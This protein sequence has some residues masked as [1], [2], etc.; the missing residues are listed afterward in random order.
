MATLTELTQDVPVGPRVDPDTVARSVADSGRVLVVLDDDPTGTQS[1]ADLPVLT[2]WSV[3]DLTWALTQ[4]KPAVYVMTNSRSLDP[5]DAEQR[6]R[7]VATAALQASQ[8]TGVPIGFVS[9]GDSTLRGHLPLEPNT[10]AHVLEQA[11]SPI[12]GIVLVPAFADAGRVTVGGVHYAGPVADGFTPVGDSEFAKDATFGYTSS[13]L[14]DWVAEKSAG[15]KP[16]DEVVVIDLATLRSGETPGQA[17]ANIL[18]AVSGGRV[19]AVDCAEENDLLLLLSLWSMRSGPAS[20]SSTASA[21]PS[22]APAS[23]SPL[24]IR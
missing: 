2:G 22:A 4:G 6:N 1:V 19:V 9:R 14:R 24:V 7:E 23:A 10:L 5:A 13:D 3:E 20:A 12:D 17:A 11:G 16:A 15:S 8:A 18:A 21:H